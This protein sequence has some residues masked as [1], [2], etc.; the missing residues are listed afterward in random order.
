MIKWL[1]RRALL[2]RRLHW[3]VSVED[4]LG[5]LY[6]LLFLYYWSL[7]YKTSVAFLALVSIAAR[8]VSFPP[9]SKKKKTPRRAGS[10]RK[11]ILSPSFPWRLVRRVAWLLDS[12]W[13]HSK[14]CEQLFFCLEFMDNSSFYSRMNSSIVPN[15]R[16]VTV[17]YCTIE[18]EVGGS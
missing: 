2:L 8:F 1:K 4:D 7:P 13:H 15:H 12:Y 11:A 5:L 10:V 9:V 14:R 18:K 3:T 17:W 6:N 16:A